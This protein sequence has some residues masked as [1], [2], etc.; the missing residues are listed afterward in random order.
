M[1]SI[2][3]LDENKIEAM[4]QKYTVISFD[5][6]DT[7]LRR[8]FIAPTDLFDYVEDQY[9]L[10]D[11][12]FKRV[13]AEAQTRKKYPD[14][15]DIRYSQIYE[16]LPVDQKHELETERRALYPRKKLVDLFKL[17]KKLGKTTVIL[18]DMYLDKSFIRATLEKYGIVADHIFVSGNDQIGKFNGSMFNHLIASLNIFPQDILHFGDNKHSDYISAIKLGIAAVHISNEA[19]FFPKL[20]LGKFTSEAIHHLKST[21]RWTASQLGAAIRDYYEE[22]KPKDS[23]EEL[24]ASMSG[25]LAFCISRWI[26]DNCELNGLKKFVFLARDGWLPK[27]AFDYIKGDIKTYYLPINRTIIVRA[28]FLSLVDELFFQLSP[29]LPI[30]KRDLLKKY[31]FTNPQIF[32]ELEH[33]MDLDS[34]MHT[35]DDMIEFLHTAKSTSRT[36]VE[37]VN[38][39][40]TAIGDLLQESDLLSNSDQVGFFDI[41]WMGS[42]FAIL[43]K[44][45]PQLQASRFYFFGTEQKFLFN[46]A[47]TSSLF[48]ERGAPENHRNLCF[49]SI[50]LV[51]TTLTAHEHSAISLSKTNG[52]LK[53]EYQ[54]DIRHEIENQRERLSRMV[55]SAEHFIDSLNEFPF[56][57]NWSVESSMIAALVTTVMETKCPLM[58]EA[59]ATVK[60]QVLS[61]QSQWTDI[62]GRTHSPRYF[63]TLV[64]WAK[65][66]PMKL[67]YGARWAIQYE[68]LYFQ[69]LKGLKKAFAFPFYFRRKKIKFLRI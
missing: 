11:F 15:I 67:G 31:Y 22:W 20:G 50:E 29:H 34:I 30:S 43:T 1:T 42:V 52:Q 37:E 68:D 58:N 69:N 10:N 49:Q 23:W 45:W 12:R 41:G 38:S 8:P 4:L 64:R 33:E 60:H 17:A 3:N 27:Y 48:F 16:N 9:K 55:R 6:F 62:S 53:I 28:A 66:R 7:L 54:K 26:K 14:Q 57:E 65:G 47:K 36:L 51:E 21:N 18:S 24:G 32:F 40:Q 46:H 35:R 63:S 5:V 19:P 25:P 61:G 13:T 39:V 59:V 56:F 2:Y 44:T